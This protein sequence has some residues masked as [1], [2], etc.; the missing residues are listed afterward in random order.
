MRLT[1]YETYIAKMCSCHKLRRYK[2]LFRRLADLDMEQRSAVAKLCRA[3]CYPPRSSRLDLLTRCLP[4][5]FKQEIL[6]LCQTPLMAGL[7][8]QCILLAPMS[9]REVDRIYKQSMIKEMTIMESVK[10]VCT[11]NFEPFFGDYSEAIHPKIPCNGFAARYVHSCIDTWMDSLG[12]KVLFPRIGSKTISKSTQYE[13]RCVSQDYVQNDEIG[14]TPIDLERVYHRYGVK[15]TGPCEMRQKW[16]S[17]I[18]QPRT[19]YAQGGDAYHSSKYLAGPLVELC[20]TLPSTNRRTRV[21]PGRIVIRDPTD[22]VAYY[23]LSSFTS[24]MHVQCAFMYRLAHYCRGRMV[25]ILDSVDGII[26]VDLGALIYD[27]TRVNLHDPGYTLPSKYS[28]PSVVHYHSVAGFLGVYGN[29]ASATFIHGIVMAMLHKRLDENNVAG[30]DGLD[31]TPN[32]DY[33]L[34][35]VGTMGIVKDEKTFR[36]KEGCSIHLKRPIVRMGGRLLQGQLITWPSLEPIQTDVDNRYP[37]LKRNNDRTRRNTIASSITAFLRKLE[38]HQLDSSD[39]DIVDT[40][41]SALYSSCD[42]PREGCVPQATRTNSGFVPTYERRFIGIDPLRNT[43]TRN[44]TYIAKLPLRGK[45]DWEYDMFNEETFR[46][47]HTKLLRHLVVLG[48]LHQEKISHLVFGNEGLKC[49]LK[50]Y[51]CPESHIYEYTIMCKL[52][53]WIIDFSA[54]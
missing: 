23:D 30:D 27:Y 2:H 46:C 24:N 51:T 48:Y 17:S 44:Y 14:I 54:F 13:L 40:F 6:P 4:L 38:F 12:R 5:S 3:Q 37:Y 1:Q 21:D 33:T 16:Y 31:V 32:V 41:L 52:P 20:D 36:D 29:I 26:S 47:N 7:V 11:L 35:V 28:D 9:Q 49:L 10:R 25:D 50:E 15:V 53:V 19:Y 39:L 45:L 22:D 8:L 43:V 42:L 18:L 34:E